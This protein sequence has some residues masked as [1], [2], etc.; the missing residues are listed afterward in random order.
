MPGIV[1]VT[2]CPPL[3]LFEVHS[4]TI[5]PGQGTRASTQATYLSLNLRHDKI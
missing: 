5:S 2:Q 4:K 3:L 1:A